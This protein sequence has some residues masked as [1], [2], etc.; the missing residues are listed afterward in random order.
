MGNFDLMNSEKYSRLYC[1]LKEQK[2]IKLKGNIYHKTQVNFTYNTNRIEGSKLT[3]DETR[4][5]FETN[6]IIGSDKVTNSNDIVETSNHFYLFDLMLDDADEVLTEDMIK[7]FHGILKNGTV[8]SRNNWFAVGDYKRHE[9]EV[10]GFDTVPPEEVAYEMRSLLDWYTSLDNASFEDIIDFHYRFE[11]IHPFQDGN[12]R[13]GRL[14]MFKEC[15][16]NNIMPF[17][18]DNEVKAFYYRGMGEYSKEKEYLI[19][20]LLAMQDQYALMVKK[21]VGDIVFVENSFS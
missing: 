13:I 11:C 21:F 7:G 18:I 16:K 12:G 9:N 20:T 15:L 5:I 4:M 2:D 1:V 14:I 3:E 8:D 19:D 10:G 17:I 6:S